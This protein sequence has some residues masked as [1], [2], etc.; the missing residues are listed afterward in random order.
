MNIISSI[1]QISTFR[2]RRVYE[3]AITQTN[4][5]HLSNMTV[6]GGII[7]KSANSTTISNVVVYNTTRNGGIVDY[8][9]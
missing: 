3:I 1:A 6:M 7:I 2:M 5:M 8:Y 4:N 9:I